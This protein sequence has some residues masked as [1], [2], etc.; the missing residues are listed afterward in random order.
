MQKTLGHQTKTGGDLLWECPTLNF[1]WSFDHVTNMSSGDK[2][3]RL[4][5]HFYE[6][7]DI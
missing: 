2:L 7:Y 3:K 1:T 6:T 5:L 4:Y